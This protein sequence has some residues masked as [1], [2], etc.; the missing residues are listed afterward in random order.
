MSEFLDEL[1][2]TIASP[3]PRRRALRMLGGALVTVAVPSAVR[4]RRAFAGMLQPGTSVGLCEKDCG[5]AFP[6][7]CICPG[8]DP[9]YCYET[10]GI[11]GSRCCCYKNADGEPTGA[12]ACPPGTRCGNPAAGESNC[13]CINTCGSPFSCCGADEYCANPQRSSAASTGNARATAG[14]AAPERGVQ[15]LPRRHR[16]LGRLHEALSPRPGVVR[17]GQVLPAEMALRQRAQRALQALPLQRG[18]VREQ[19]LRPPHLALLRRGRLLPEEPLVLRE[20]P[21][22]GLLPAPHEVRDP[23]PPRQHRHPSADARDLLPGR[24]SQQQSEALLPG[25]PDRAQQ[26]GPP[27]PAARRQPVSAA[28]AAWCAGPAAARSARTSSPIR[29]TAAHAATSASRACATGASARS[30]EPAPTSCVASKH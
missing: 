10:C 27:H 12:A 23:D 7:P 4:P 16:K 3:M 6:V 25:G 13:M 29:R 30:R 2:R 21:A 20:R 19:V 1:A 24:A 22:A 26:P 5:G 9:K 17:P 8:P 11:P 14:S 28:P 18:G 15:D